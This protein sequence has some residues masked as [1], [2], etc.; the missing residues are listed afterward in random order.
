MKTI[1]VNADLAE[2]LGTDPQV[3]WDISSANLCLGG[4]AGD[5]EDT[6]WIAQLCREEGVRIGLH[7]GYPDRERFGRVSDPDRL[8]AWLDDIEKQVKWGMKLK[9]AYLKPHGAFYHDTQSPGPAADRLAALL[10]QWKLPLMGYP[11]THHEAIA[12]HGFIREGFADRGLDEAGRL[13]PRGQPGAIL[14]AEAAAAQAVWLA[15]R[16]DSICLHG[17]REDI[18]EVAP[19]MRAA[20]ED[21]GYQVTAP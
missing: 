6:Q 19:R 3:L 16:V 10:K 1:D 21:A 8:A 17:D 20:L 12:A 7:P 5:R 13:I 4:H 11:G 9:P 15:E 2:G 18:L 14:S